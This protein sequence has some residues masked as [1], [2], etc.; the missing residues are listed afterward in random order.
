MLSYRRDEK[1]DLKGT[2]IGQK[3]FKDKKNNG[4]N[5]L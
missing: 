1:A 5:G 4:N 3:S 2:S